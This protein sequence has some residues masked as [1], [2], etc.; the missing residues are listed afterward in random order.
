MLN[1]ALHVTRKLKRPDLM[2]DLA[3]YEQISG[4]DEKFQ[5]SAQYVRISALHVTRFGAVC[6]DFGAAC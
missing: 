3:L 6:Q 2:Q 5:D 1:S 4:L